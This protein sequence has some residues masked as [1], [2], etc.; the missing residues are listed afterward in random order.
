MNDWYES[1]GDRL[2]YRETGAGLPVIFLH[3]TPLDHDYWR[4]LMDELAG[5]RAVAPDFRG[6]GQSE[7]GAGL[8]LGGFARA[9]GAA[10]LGMDRLAADV[11]A[12]LDHLELERAT[13]VGCSIGGYVLLELWR[14]IPERMEALAFICSKAQPDSE[15][16]LEKRATSIA[17]IAAQGTAGFFDGLAQTL[18]GA[19]ARERHPGI[20]AELRARMTLTPRAAMAVQAG[21]AMRPDSMPTIE[22]IDVPVLAIAGG[23]DSGITPAEMEAFNAA[24]GGC[25]F[26]LL[27]DAGHFAAY[28]QPQKVAALLA[29]WLKQ[30]EA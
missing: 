7:L 16:N 3:P 27:P 20:V 22:T 9:P 30:P 13:F 4:P 24:P 8:A 11:I 26:H 28:E 2:F 21:L 25:E 5:V 6:H 17:Q 10:V 12:L 15:A 14:R 19:S 29:E 18:I 23:E 1:D